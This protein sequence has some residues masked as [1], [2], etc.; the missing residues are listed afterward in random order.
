MISE[1]EPVDSQESE[2][3]AGMTDFMGPAVS[4]NPTWQNLP[5]HLLLPKDIEQG[6]V[7][8]GHFLP[9]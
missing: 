1:G 4:C 2:G 6:A 9:H 7:S 8:G 3:A 5:A